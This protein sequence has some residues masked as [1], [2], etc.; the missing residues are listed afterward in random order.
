M[1]NRSIGWVVAFAAVVVVI[2]MSIDPAAALSSFKGRLN[3]LCLS[4]V[5]TEMICESDPASLGESGELI[6][7]GE[8]SGDTIAHPD[9]DSRTFQYLCL[10]KTWEY[11][12][13]SGFCCAAENRTFCNTTQ[14]TGTGNSIDEG[15]ARR[16]TKTLTAG[17]NRSK[18]YTCSGTDWT[19]SADTGYCCAPDTV[20]VCGQGYTTRTGRDH[21]DD[22]WIRSGFD[23][24]ERYECR[25]DR[26][27]LAGSTGKCCGRT[28]QP[29]CGGT[30]TMPVEGDQG[31][32]RYVRSGIHQARY[33]C[34]RGDWRQAEERC[35]CSS[36]SKTMCG[37]SVSLPNRSDGQ[38]VTRRA[39]F[40]R[41][42]TYT[43]SDGS[44]QRSRDGGTCG[45]ERTT[46]NLCGET[47]T[48]PAGPDNKTVNRSA[49]YDRRAEYTCRNQRWQRTSA[50]GQCES[51]CE[52]NRGRR[53][54][55]ATHGRKRVDTGGKTGT[56]G[57]AGSFRLEERTILEI[58]SWNSSHL[59]YNWKNPGV[60]ISGRNI[61]IP[62]LTGWN[63]YYRQNRPSNF[64]PGRHGRWPG[65]KQIELGAGRH[66]V[67]WLKRCRHD[68]CYGR[69]GQTSSTGCGKGG[70]QACYGLV[71]WYFNHNRVD[72]RVVG[73]P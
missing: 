54:F 71:P 64:R 11:D 19:E 5:P 46:K 20:S 28:R 60:R 7:D 6:I 13:A 61:W 39:G 56:L 55:Y 2:L 49:G 43:C 38:S 62:R 9:S 50:S 26:W 32:N 59:G 67:H 65:V 23:R 63:S 72:I 53:V 14:S 69:Y 37:E 41:F 4:N 25:G 15:S 29:I 10:G 57:Y 22:Q 27:Q 16:D 21:G 3:S 18:T 24:R 58:K 8:K 47:Q 70:R 12:A 35:G 51:W 66:H 40:D 52:V 44:W 45:C 30:I 31:D 68:E 1:Q 48:L 73:C 42:E 17:D 34:R 33:I 36:S